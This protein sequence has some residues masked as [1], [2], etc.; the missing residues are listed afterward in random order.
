MCF[1]VKVNRV[2]KKE[3]IGNVSLFSPQSLLSSWQHPQQNRPAPIHVCHWS[4]RGRS[5]LAWAPRTP[6]SHPRPGR[7]VL[8]LYSHVGTEWTGCSHTGPLPAQIYKQYTSEILH[9]IWD[10]ITDIIKDIIICESRSAITRYEL[11]MERSEAIAKCF[12]PTKW[13]Q[14]L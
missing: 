7:P 3:N 12:I 14:S 11:R 4:P 9:I 8:V 1:E 2:R 13:E 10:M 5:H 6:G